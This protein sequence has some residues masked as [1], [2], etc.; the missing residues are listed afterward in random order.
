MYIS[1]LVLL[2]D[3]MQKDKSA[4]QLIIKQLHIVW[5]DILTFNLMGNKK[6][7]LHFS[8]YAI[9][10]ECKYVSCITDNGLVFVLQGTEYYSC[11]T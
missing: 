2:L 11:Y 5:Y 4:L 9:W 10:N 1:V 7:D 6:S 8:A 3:E